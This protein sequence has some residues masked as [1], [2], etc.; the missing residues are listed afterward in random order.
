MPPAKARN[1]TWTVRQSQLPFWVTEVLAYQYM[2]SRVNDYR[3]A[4]AHG[5]AVL[6]QF[7]RNFAAEFFELHR[8][9]SFAPDMSDQDL[10]YEEEGVILVLNGIEEIRRSWF[11]VRSS[12]DSLEKHREVTIVIGKEELRTHTERCRVHSG[13]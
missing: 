11:E 8:I 9:E 10:L 5:D 13:A 4:K 7:F 2:C 3:N 1:Y 12:S 6:S